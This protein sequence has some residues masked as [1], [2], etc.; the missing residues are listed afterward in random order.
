MIYL[1]GL[2]FTNREYEEA[3]F[4]F[5]VNFEKMYITDRPCA[6]LYKCF[7]GRML[8]GRVDICL[9]SGFL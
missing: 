7:S 1:F 4:K 5:P 2:A 9:N 6:I 8:L 3:T